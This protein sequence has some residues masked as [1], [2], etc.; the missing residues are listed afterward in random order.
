MES[1]ALLSS[2][3][4]AFMTFMQHASRGRAYFWGAEGNLSAGIHLCPHLVHRNLQLHSFCW[5]VNGNV[6]IFRQRID[7]VYFW[8]NPGLHAPPFYSR[9]RYSLNVCPRVHSKQHLSIKEEGKCG[10]YTLAFTDNS[11]CQTLSR[12]SWWIKIVHINLFSYYLNIGV[13]IKC[14]LS[15]QRIRMS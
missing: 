13:L 4:L 7:I 3:R 2:L 15:V 6:T 12:V 10:G 5:T 8:G 14:Q 9:F 1:T 11:W